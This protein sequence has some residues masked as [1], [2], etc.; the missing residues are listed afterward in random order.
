MATNLFQAPPIAPFNVDDPNN[1]AVRW[2]RWT[3]RLETYITAT[4]ITDDKQMRSLLLFCAGDAVHEDIRQ[5][6]RS[7]RSRRLYKATLKL[8]TD[9]FSPK[10]NRT[11]EIYTFRQ[12]KQL[13]GESVAQFYTRLRQLA[14]TCEF[15]GPEGEIRSQIIQR[16]TSKKLR[17]TALRR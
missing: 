12:A 17:E 16:C 11:F 10:K 5:L 13:D 8:L 15:T 2:N 1:I 4:G 14:S 3:K 7:T 6:T 9:H